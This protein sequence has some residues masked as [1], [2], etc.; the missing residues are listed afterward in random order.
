MKT[1]IFGL[2]LVLVLA[3]VA[4]CVAETPA[5]P[6]VTATR[7]ATA[8]PTTTLTPTSTVT[9]SRTL[10]PRT[11]TATFPPIET[12]A[13]AEAEQLLIEHLQSIPECQ[14]PC[15]WGVTP[16]ETSFHEAYKMLF[17]FGYFD[18]EKVKTRTF[19]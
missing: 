11:P 9:P 10:I 12:V 18:V 1:K 4:G 6:T 7:T 17:P 8:S 2:V 19:N 3:L 14:L 16:G 5:A 13:P 15:I